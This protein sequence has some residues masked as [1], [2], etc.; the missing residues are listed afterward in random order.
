MNNDR[1]SRAA[2]ALFLAIGALCLPVQAV[3]DGDKP[4]AAEALSHDGLVKLKTRVADQVYARPG[5][6]VA[7]YTQ[8]LMG[9]VDVAFAKDWDPKRTGSGFRISNAEREEIRRGVATI[10]REEFVKALQAKDGYQLVEAVAPGALLLKVSILDLYVNAPD[11]ASASMTRTYVTSAGEMTLVLEALDSE[12]GQVLARVVDR[13][14]S[15]LRGRQGMLSWSNRI[16]N[17]REAE[18]IAAGWARQLRKSL[19][20]VREIGSK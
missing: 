8:V 13:Q 17:A 11:E 3:Q 7:G 1:S 9:P 15:D 4:P 2:M 12:T 10:V 20:K 18:L 6:S 14:E 16:T 5:A 19:D